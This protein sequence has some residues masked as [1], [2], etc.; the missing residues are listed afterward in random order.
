MSF[1]PRDEQGGRPSSQSSFCASFSPFPARPSAAPTTPGRAKAG[2]PISNIEPILR[3][4]GK[5]AVAGLTLSDSLR[6]GQESDR[7]VVLRQ[8]DPINRPAKNRNLRKG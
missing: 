4:L 5:Q 1:S 6:T 2:T 7:A 3:F 8:H